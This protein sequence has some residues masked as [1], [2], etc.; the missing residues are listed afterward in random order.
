MRWVTVLFLCLCAALATVNASGALNTTTSSAVTV[1]ATSQ[2]S[3]PAQSELVQKVKAAT[4]GLQV[5]VQAISA[6]D[7][8]KVLK[9]IGDVLAQ[10]PDGFGYTGVA[11]SLA[12]SVVSLAGGTTKK[13]DPVLV[14]LNTL[15]HNFEQDVDAIQFQLRCI[16]DQLSDVIVNIDRVLDGIFDIPSKVMAEM[17]M[18][19]VSVMKDKFA[20]IQRN[21]MLYAQG[22]LTRSQMISKCDDFEIPL[23]F[24]ELKTIL[25]DEK[26]L[27]G[28]KFEVHDHANG[29]VQLHLFGFYISVIPVVANCNALKYSLE[30]TQEDG[31]R[32]NEIIQVAIERAAWCLMPADRAVHVKEQFAPFATLFEVG[33]YHEKEGYKLSL[34]FKAYS[35]VPPH[36]GCYQVTP[37]GSQLAPFQVD[38]RLRTP[39][40]NVFCVKTV[41]TDDASQQIAYAERSGGS[42]SVS[43]IQP[44]AQNAHTFFAPTVGHWK[45]FA[46]MS[47]IADFAILQANSSKT[48]LDELAQT[49]QSFGEGYDR[50]GD[51]H[52]KNYKDAPWTI[53][54]VRYVKRSIREIDTS[55]G[56]F[57][58]DVQL[59]EMDP[60]KA[61]SAACPDEGYARATNTL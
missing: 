54:C 20:N 34:S 3:V 13:P 53:F 42:T 14:A 44:E 23:P 12:A 4:D 5:A 19:D 49:C 50:D 59:N 58:T 43:I 55:T 7:V 33:E 32:V 40:P 11:F 25:K 45:R 38:K 17:K 56:S 47:L 28:A 48:S 30:S 2:L 57:L 9:G 61:W 31:K 10:L 21:A 15:S 6:Q 16:E 52:S 27:F 29:Q 39:S 46:P 8:A 26:D 35:I 36:G 60:G 18:T 22:N 1:K 24:A 41:A 51:G 37:D